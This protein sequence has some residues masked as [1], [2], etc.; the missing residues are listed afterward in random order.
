MADEPDACGRCPV[1][2]DAPTLEGDND[3]VL[4][5]FQAVRLSANLVTAEDKTY[6]Y[7]RPEAIESALRLRLIPQDMWPTISER[8]M[9]LNEIENQLKRVRKQKK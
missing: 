1:A 2:D 9:I 3:L 5:V 4:E 8:V 7:I 6:S